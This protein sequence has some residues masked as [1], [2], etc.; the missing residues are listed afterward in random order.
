V[1]LIQLETI[2]NAPLEACFDASRSIDV[3]KASV[4]SNSKEEAI[5]GIKSGLIELGEFVQ[6]RAKHFGLYFKMTV[7]ITEM[8]SPMLFIDEQIKGPFKVMRHKHTFIESNGKT[9]M[10]DEFYFESPFGVLGKVVDK[11]ILK[12]YL[13][14]LL[15]ERNDYIKR[16]LESK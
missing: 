6:W 10:K 1:P 16:S 2:I 4:P 14:S 15:F 5:G 9:L 13:S 12:K 3:H 8:Y 11:F 7:K